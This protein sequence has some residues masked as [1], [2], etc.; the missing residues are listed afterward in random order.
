[1]PESNWFLDKIRSIIICAF[2]ALTI[3][4]EQFKTKITDLKFKQ[5][6]IFCFC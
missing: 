2:T 1:M 5:T 3:E 6:Q 4:P